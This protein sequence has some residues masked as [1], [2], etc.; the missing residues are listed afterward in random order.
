MKYSYSNHMDETGKYAKW[1]KPV[2]KDLILQDP[3]HMQI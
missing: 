3:I 2:T 1:K